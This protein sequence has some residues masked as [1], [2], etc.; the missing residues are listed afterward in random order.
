MATKKDLVQH[1]NYLNEKYCKNTKNHFVISQAYGGY[2]VALTGKTYK[3]G[4]RTYWRKGSIGSGHGSTLI[5]GIYTNPS[6]FAAHQINKYDSVE[7]IYILDK[8]SYLDVETKKKL[9]GSFFNIK[10]LSETTST[11]SPYQLKDVI[12]YVYPKQ[13]RNE[14]TSKNK[15][16]RRKLKQ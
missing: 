2:S 6:S 11:I 10:D 15:Y 5:N 8:D 4:K 13:P 7:N 12:K 9:N 16:N 3:R 14:V 1:V